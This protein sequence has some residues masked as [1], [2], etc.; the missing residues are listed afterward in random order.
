MSSRRRQSSPDPLTTILAGFRRLRFEPLERRSMLAADADIVDPVADAP[1][2][3]DLLVVPE[4]VACEAAIPEMVECPVVEE[5]M[6][7]EPLWLEPEMLVV[8]DQ[9]PVDEQWFKDIAEE[10]VTDGPTWVE[11][12]ALDEGEESDQAIPLF[13]GCSLSLTSFVAD[14]PELVTVDA[15]EEHVDT[16]E[17]VPLEDSWN[18]SWSGWDSGEEPVLFT[19]EETFRSLTLED[20]IPR[21]V[22]SIAAVPGDDADPEVP[23]AVVA[24]EDE[25]SILAADE[26]AVAFTAGIAAESVPGPFER[27]GTEAPEPVA[28][29]ASRAGAA[30]MF[31]AFSA[32]A[33]A[34]AQPWTPVNG[35]RG[36]RR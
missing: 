34:D 29:A 8:D 9:W 15:V 32:G 12:L 16:L 26:A 23:V 25:P 6:W 22:F 13:E 5:C 1:S 14:W 30:R 36:P 18:S 31:A 28:F 4:V 17:G 2:P 21:P 10:A 24:A 33:G 19:G 11:G 7:I 3:D 27:V 20:P 35:R